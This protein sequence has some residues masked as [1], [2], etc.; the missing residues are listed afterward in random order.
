MNNEEKFAYVIKYMGIEEKEIAE[1]FGMSKSSISRFKNEKGG[2]IITFKKIHWYGMEEFFGIPRKIF[3]DNNITNKSQIEDILDAKKERDKFEDKSITIK[4]QIKDILDAQ[5]ERDKFELFTD[6]KNILKKLTGVW[7]IYLYASNRNRGFYEIITTI[8]D[9]Y[10]VF[11]QNNNEG[12]LFISENQSMII[13]KSDNSRNLVSITFNNTEVSYNIFKCS[14]ISRSNQ[15]EIEMLSFGFIS[16]NILSKEKAKNVL[17]NIKHLQ[18]RI[19]ED[20]KERLYDY[21]YLK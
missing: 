19:N 16:K 17:G 1:K 13:K 6:N 12:Q 3:E 10:S 11:D 9:D 18:L 2:S 21:V 15:S 7:Y 14:I 5:T 20:F 4:K 8:N